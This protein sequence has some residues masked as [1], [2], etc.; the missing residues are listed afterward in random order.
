MESKMKQH[1]RKQKIESPIFKGLNL[2]LHI[3][4]LYIIVLSSIIIVL[5]FFSLIYAAYEGIFFQSGT[6]LFLCSADINIKTGLERFI[7]RYGEGLVK[8]QEMITDG[9]V[10]KCQD[11]VGKLQQLFL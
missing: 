9:G 6:P 4:L 10:K 7:D 11:L 8:K 3:I 5:S 1:Y 2:V